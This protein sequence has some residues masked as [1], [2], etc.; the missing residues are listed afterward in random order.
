MKTY[1]LLLVCLLLAFG[2]QAQLPTYR[3]TVSV[4]FERVGLDGPDAIGNRYLVRYARHLR[5]DRIALMANLGYMSV[6]NRVDLPGAANYYVEGKRRQRVTTDL[7]AAFDFIR[8]P[9]HAFRLGAGPSLWYRQEE[10]S[11]GIHYTLLSD[12]SVTNVRADW[13]PE[14]GFD[15]G[16]NVL[17]E[18]EY[19]LTDHLLL[20]GKVKF[21][22]LGDGGGQS[23][24]Y[25]GGIG[26]RL[27]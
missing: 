27:R 2:V 10:L 19:A 11:N 22:D 12:G 23:S 14:K 1:L 9:R 17:I 24:I 18:Y 13:R 16:F 21:V 3:H 15:F 25:G 5:N 20:S 26:Y 8:H 4:G 6:L 7:T